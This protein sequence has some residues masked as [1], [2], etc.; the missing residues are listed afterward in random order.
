MLITIVYL[1]IIFFKLLPIEPVFYL[2]MASAITYLIHYHFNS[3]KQLAMLG[4]NE[5]YI[6]KVKFSSAVRLVGIIVF[7]VL[8]AVSFK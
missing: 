8:L 7:A 5:G 2:F 1:A 3:A 4:I 6:Y